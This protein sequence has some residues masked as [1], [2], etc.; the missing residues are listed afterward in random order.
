MLMSGQDVKERKVVHF[1]GKAG[2]TY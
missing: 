1:G 2:Q